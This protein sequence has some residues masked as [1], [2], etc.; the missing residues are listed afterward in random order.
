MASREEFKWHS[1]LNDWKDAIGDPVTCAWGIFAPSV[2]FGR[3]VN[4][5]T[6]GRTSFMKAA[7]THLA[8]GGCCCW[9]CCLPYYSAPFREQLRKKRNLPMDPY[10]DINTHR[11]CHPCA[12]CQEERELDVVSQT[13]VAGPKEPTVDIGE[14]DTMKKLEDIQGQKMT[15]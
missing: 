8:M 1:G 15:R 3:N 4:R 14:E 7:L 9:C 12:I 11:W 13:A 10:S 6:D 5:I 2:L